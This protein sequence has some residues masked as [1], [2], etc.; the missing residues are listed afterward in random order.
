MA[1]LEGVELALDNNKMVREM[2]FSLMENAD[3]SK[4][5]NMIAFL[6]EKHPDYE[7]EVEI[8]IEKMPIDMTPK[9]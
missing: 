3:M 9:K 6:H 5:A 8:D 2:T 7:I 4:V 1:Q